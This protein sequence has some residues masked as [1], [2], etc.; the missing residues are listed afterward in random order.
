M[1]EWSPGH[2]K[3]TRERS[4]APPGLTAAL[5]IPRIYV[6]NRKTQYIAL[7]SY[8]VSAGLRF[9]SVFQ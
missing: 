5:I 1:P 4:D 7:R 8:A 6:P 9:F 2:Q 3:H